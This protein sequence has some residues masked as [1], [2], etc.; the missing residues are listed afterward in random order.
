MYSSLGLSTP[1]PPPPPTVYLS[2]SFLR[3]GLSQ[4]LECGQPIWGN[5]AWGMGMETGKLATEKVGRPHKGVFLPESL[6]QATGA[7]PTCAQ[8]CLSDRR[9]EHPSSASESPCESLSSLQILAG[10]HAVVSRKPGGTAQ[11]RHDALSLSLCKAG[12]HSNQDGWDV[13][14]EEVRQDSRTSPPSPCTDLV[15]PVLSP[16]C[17][18]DFKGLPTTIST[19]DFGR[20][21][22]W[23]IPWFVISQLVP[24]PLPTPHPLFPS[25]Q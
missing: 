19:K 1:P 21:D 10:L 11:L 24:S 14:Q 2:L 3:E 9:E 25:P 17:H 5:E 16:V 7:Q 13:G 20:E 6:L 12:Y 8:N 18:K 23:N 22:E 4:N 15:M